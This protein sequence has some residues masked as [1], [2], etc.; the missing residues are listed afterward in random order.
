MFETSD[1]Q[2]FP[3]TLLP[4]VIDEEYSIEFKIDVQK[5]ISAHKGNKCY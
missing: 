1:Y 4:I 3:Y 5:Y 2:M